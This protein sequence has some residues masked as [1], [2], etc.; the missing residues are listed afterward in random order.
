MRI[1]TALAV[2]LLTVCAPGAALAE[3]RTHTVSISALA[4]TPSSL[5]VKKGDT[6]IFINN[7]LVPHT[8]TDKAKKAFDSGV[9]TSGKE[10]R[11]T[12]S[13]AGKVDYYCIIHPTMEGSIV[14][15]E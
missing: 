14:V 15:T 11:L 9:L 8:V 13:E 1:R 3:S 4:F 10:W 2:L 7:D 5:T 12:P 6:V